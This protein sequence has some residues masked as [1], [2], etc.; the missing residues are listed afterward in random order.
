M[1]KSLYSV[2]STIWYCSYGACTCKL[3]MM[4]NYHTGM[5]NLYMDSGG[6]NHS[7]VDT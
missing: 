4:G 3:G 7:S 1:A 2:R 5:D 6:E